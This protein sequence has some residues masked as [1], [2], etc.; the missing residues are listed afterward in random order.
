[1]IEYEGLL[2]IF[3]YSHSEKWAFRE[4]PEHITSSLNIIASCFPINCVLHM[5]RTRHRKTDLF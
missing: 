1:M 4:I 2:N 5:G 3:D